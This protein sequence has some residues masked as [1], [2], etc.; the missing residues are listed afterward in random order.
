MIRKLGISILLLFLFLPLTL[1]QYTT[2]TLELTIYEDGYVKVA[3]IITPEEYTVM[4]DVPLMGKNIKGLMVRNENNDPLLYKLNNS[5]LSIYFENA[6]TIMVIY[7]TPDLTSKKGALWSVN[8]TSDVPITI[9]FPENAVIV[10]LNTVP[11]KINKNKLTMPPGNISISYIIESDFPLTASYSEIPNSPSPPSSQQGTRW[12]LYTI[13]LFAILVLG[14][15]LLFKKRSPKSA[16]KIVPLP[17]TR[18]EFQ[19]KIEEMDLSRDEIRVLLY[20][21]DRGGKAPQAEIKDVLR[22]PKTT[23]WRMFKRLEEK[24]LIRIYK[25]KRENWV[26]LVF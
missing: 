1:A 10:G 22:I 23:A 26:E 3:Q 15:Y 8:L 16:K 18:E 12:Y 13:P 21:Y 17:L 14:G 19:K 20:L 7:Y 11:L 24:G 4:V 6:S 9:N 25:K 2:E 5:L